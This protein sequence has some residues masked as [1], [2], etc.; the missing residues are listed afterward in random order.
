M[1]SKNEYYRGQMFSKNKYYRVQM[2]SKNEYY[3]VQ[4][5]SKNEFVR[6]FERN[7]L[8]GFIAGLNYHTQVINP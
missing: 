4:M 1:F 3:R 5:F 2:L 6:E 8:H 7:I